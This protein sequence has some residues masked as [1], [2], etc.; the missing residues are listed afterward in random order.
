MHA[1]REIVALKTIEDLWPLF[2]LVIETERLQL[3]LPRE[4]DLFDLAQAG[5][6]LASPGENQ[7]L[8]D[9]WIYG[10]SPLME[11]ELLRDHWRMLANWKPDSWNLLLAICLDGRPIGIQALMAT[12]FPHLRTVETGAWIGRAEQG[13]GYGTEAGIAVLKLA[14]DWLGAEE[15]Q[16]RYLEGNDR[17]SGIAAKLSYLENGQHRFYRDHTGHTTE[18]RVRLERRTWLE[19]HPD[20]HCLITGLEPCLSMFG[21]ADGS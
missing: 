11:Q 14:F 19:N 3:R 10:P 2:G 18:H 13:R 15:A 6:S 21:A 7:F 9:G 12:D 8:F 4:H 20:D 1:S 17:S 5:R 16:G